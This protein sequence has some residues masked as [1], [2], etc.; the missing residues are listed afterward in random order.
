MRSVL[1]LT[2]KELRQNAMVALALAV[3]LCLVY[4]L[5]IFGTWVGPRTLSMFEAHL[6]F[7]RVFLPVLALAAGN[8]LVVAEYHGRT[9]LFLESLP[10]RRVEMLL[11]KYGLG[12]SALLAATLASL[13]LCALV[14]HGREAVD[15]RF[16]A[17]LA[18]RTSGVTFAAFAFVFV[19]GF[20]GRLRVPLY[21][22]ILMGLMLLHEHTELELA[23]FGPFALIDD[24]LPLERDDFPVRAL[25]ETMAFGAGLSVAAFVLALVDEGS[26]AEVLARSMSQR[27]KAL[28]GFVFVGFAIAGSALER[29]R[30][31]EPFEFEET[32]VLRS[33]RP[34]VAIHYGEPSRRA[35]AEALLAA[36]EADRRAIRRALGWR[37][38]PRLNVAYRGDLDA[39]TVESVSLPNRE[40][41]LLR[42]RFVAEDGT[43]DSE[44]LRF[45]GCATAIHERTEHRA[46]F[47]P[48]GWVTDGFC[49]H[50]VARSERASKSLLRGL[51]ATRETSVT[52]DA[53]VAWRRTNEELGYR[54]AEGIAHTG[55][56]VLEREGGPEA[57]AR[58][59]RAFLGE[60]APEDAR[61]LLFERAHPV[62]ERV[63]AGTGR[64][65]ED[66][67]RAW[68]AALPA[69]RA[70]HSE[71]I[72]RVLDVRGEVAVER[73]AGSL[74]RI[75]A[76][77]VAGPGGDLGGSMASLR[78]EPLGAF[79]A[80]LNDLDVDREERLA[81][82]GA[83]E[84]TIALDG[85]Y[86]PGERVFV[87]A[88]IEDPTLDCAI[89]VA[90]RRVTV[91]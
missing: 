65:F 75:R 37:D 14:A 26:V 53:L 23:R 42:A 69:M 8:R 46:Y 20:T 72:A 32:H 47:E 73:G 35:A 15:A 56:A 44:E 82:P 38:L 19:M 29:Q 43:V 48:Q 3:V 89:R 17:I 61:A 55:F 57:P 91:P 51:W 16:L 68:N 80:P 54:V 18:A 84:V 87:A 6:A 63:R 83:R 33:E 30:E 31:H 70:E 13:G 5:V 66:F 77:I 76:R 78:H 49:R 27:E 71:E 74:A 67:L 85:R 39:H 90:A 25:V 2:L 50:L 21:V 11:V 86:S 60:V 64:S 59:A 36:L 88:E 22:A 10:M 34:G 1:A 52:E 81:E 9:Q 41:V 24:R 7:L 79:D 62:G 58:L 12:L 45:Y 4:A 40:G 28:A